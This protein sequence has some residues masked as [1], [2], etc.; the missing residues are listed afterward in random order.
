MDMASVISWTEAHPVEAFVIGAGGTLALLW[1]F[2]AFSGGSGSQSTAAAGTANMAAAYYAAE[3]QQ[4]VVGGQI[5]M[6]NI[7]ATAQTAQ[8][9]LT[10]NG[11]VAINAAQQNAAEIINGQNADSALNA[12]YSNNAAIVATNASNNASANYIANNATS[13]TSF[14]QLM[15]LIIPG[16]MAR[17][18]AGSYNI[19]TPSG[20]IGVTGGL[21]SMGTPDYYQQAG[22][23]LADATALARQY[24][25]AHP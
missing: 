6:A 8:T 25:A 19:Y 22:Y 1:L 14:N 13:A 18:G 5:Q 24:V 17:V 12:T 2:G 7:N 16:E 4:A 15:G 10:T 3:A 23:N 11:A 20:T 9:A 21:S